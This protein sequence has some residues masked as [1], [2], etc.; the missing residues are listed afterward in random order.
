MAEKSMFYVGKKGLRLEGARGRRESGEREY[1]NS[2]LVSFVVAVVVC[3]T[4]I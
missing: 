1:R 2:T 3:S 4:E